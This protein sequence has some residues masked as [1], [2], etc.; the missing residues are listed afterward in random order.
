MNGKWSLEGELGKIVDIPA[1]Q[2]DK[3]AQG[4]VTEQ[5]R[6]ALSATEKF[7]LW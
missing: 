5:N 2:D 1:L 3:A 7:E 4:Q 6:I